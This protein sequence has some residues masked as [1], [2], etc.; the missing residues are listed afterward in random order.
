MT[1]SRLRRLPQMLQFVFTGMTACLDRGTSQLRGR[2]QL[3]N[4]PLQDRDRA[5][6]AIAQ[7]SASALPWFC[8][9][10]TTC[11]NSASAST[12][13]SPALRG[14]DAGGRDAHAVRRSLGLRV[15]E[16]G[17]GVG[18]QDLQRD[19]DGFA[20]LCVI[21]GPSSRY[22][23][24]RLLKSPRRTAAYRCAQRAPAESASQGRV[25][26]LARTMPRARAGK[27]GAASRSSSEQLREAAPFRRVSMPQRPG[28]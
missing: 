6:D 27:V 4:Q 19:Q 16:R 26:R 14:R 21:E 1:S 25:K 2:E 13:P 12:A 10:V 18:D 28:V 17:L 5:P 22:F 20:D 11:R 9:F 15:V 3:G 24:R 7:C 23:P 8:S